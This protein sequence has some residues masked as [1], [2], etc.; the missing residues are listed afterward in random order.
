MKRHAVAGLQWTGLATLATSAF[1]YVQ[2]AVLT[3][4]LSPADFGLMAMAMVVIG[5]VQ[6][7]NDMGI[8]NAVIQRRDAAGERLSSL[9]WLE[10][11]AGLGLFAITLAITP[12]TVSFY[13]EPALLPVML[14]VS[15]IFLVTPP[16]QLYLVLLQRDLKFKDLAVIEISATVV[17][18]IAMFAAALIGMGVI[19]L[20]AG[21][22]VYYAA[23]S[24]QLVAAGLPHWRPRLH[25]RAA[26]LAGYFGFGAYQMGE[27]T[28]TYLG[29]NAIKIIVGRYL[30]A[31]V[32]GLYYIAYQ[33]IVYPVLR[34][35]TVIM[36]VSFPILAKFQES[37]D[38]LRRGYLHM[39]R[40]ISF[41][42]FPVLVVAFVAA[43]VFAPL[44]VGPGWADVTPIVQILC[45]VALF[46]A[47]GSTTV[48]TYLAR[49]RADLG[50]AWNFIV[51]VV[52]AVVFYLLAGYGIVVL[53]L[54]FAA[55]SLLQFVVMQTITG[56]M[57]GL[58]WSK[59]LGAMAINAMKSVVVGALVYAAYTI[60]SALSVNSLV[61]LVAMAAVSV[62][63]YLS[64]ALAFNRDYLRELWHL[65]LRPHAEA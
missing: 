63:A 51:A 59:Y 23:R 12:L 49:G 25:F 5:V 29:I 10:I 2:V 36:T 47:L 4:F 21:Q 28:V 35:S 14:W 15:T 18:T 46:K 45:V 16:G 6:A 3:R 43:P 61:L 34:V 37:D 58:K 26:D 30:G 27:R 19:A 39:S 17:S 41:S 13:R 1:Q 64:I 8:S 22:I 38:L 40:L 55:I 50:F 33:I 20:V 32:L 56:H 42:L 60:G 9:F 24:L 48:P 52:N 11:A 62:V 44:L 53:T 54:A 31:D 65:V 57:I 7:F